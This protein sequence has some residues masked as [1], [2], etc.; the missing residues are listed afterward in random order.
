MYDSYHEVSVAPAD[1]RD[2]EEYDQ[3]VYLV[4]PIC[5]SGDILAHDRVLP[6]CKEGDGIIL[7]DAGAYGFAMASSYNSRPLPA[8]VLIQKDGKVRLIRRAQ[9][10]KDLWPSE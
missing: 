2:Y 5:E 1:N 9:F 8:E 6:V 3:P 7:H 4:G 10:L